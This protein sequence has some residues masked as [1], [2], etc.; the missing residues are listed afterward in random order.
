VTCFYLPVTLNRL[1]IADPLAQEHCI[2]NRMEARWGLIVRLIHCP[3]CAA[4]K[5]FLDVAR[6]PAVGDILPLRRPAIILDNIR[7]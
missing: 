1:T 3:R 6:I 4:I 2:Y 5:A 7:I